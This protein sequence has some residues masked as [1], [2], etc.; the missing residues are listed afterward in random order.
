MCVHTC[1]MSECVTAERGKQRAKTIGPDLVLPGNVQ[2]RIGVPSRVAAIAMTTWGRSAR[3]VLGVA[4][5][6]LGLLEWAANPV[7]V[8]RLGQV[9]Q[10]VGTL[11]LPVCA[12]AV[13]AVP[14]CAGLR[15]TPTGGCQRCTRALENLPRLVRR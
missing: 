6:P 4:E 9:G 2:H 14:R 5:G 10:L 12:R 13:G 11:D 3:E 15:S 7:V 8:D 1:D